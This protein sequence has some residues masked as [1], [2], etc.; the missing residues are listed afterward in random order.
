MIKYLLKKSK[1][2]SFQFKSP[3]IDTKN[4]LHSCKSNK[5]FLELGFLFPMPVKVFFNNKDY[6]AEK[7]ICVIKE[8]I[9]METY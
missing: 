1:C 5:I 2:V 8:L 9:A 7:N 4:I 6:P 3:T